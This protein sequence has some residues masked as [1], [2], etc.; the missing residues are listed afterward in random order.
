[1]EQ[2]LKFA[3]EIFMCVQ[4]APS[5]NIG[6]HFDRNQIKLKH[7]HFL[8]TQWGKKLFRLRSK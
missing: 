3:E 5:G 6:K 1:M 8:Q 7:G 2:T 4:N